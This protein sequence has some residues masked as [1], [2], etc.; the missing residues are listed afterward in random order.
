MARWWPPVKADRFVVFDAVVDVRDRVEPHRVAVAI[1]DDHRLIR[2]RVHQLAIGQHRVGAVRSVDG[3]GRQVHVRVLDGVGRVVDADPVRRQGAGIEVD[4][5]GILRRTSYLNLRHATHRGNPLRNRRFGVFVDGGDRKD[6]RAQDEL[7][8]RLVA[9]VHLLV[10]RGHRH[11]RRE[12]TRRFRNHRL[13]VL[14]RRID[15]PIE[16]ELQR[17]VRVPLRARR[18]DR[19]ETGDRRKLF[20]ERQCDRRGHR[21][22]TGTGETPLDLN[23]REVDDRQIADGQ[24]AIRHHAEDQNSEHDERRGDRTCDEECREVHGSSVREPRVNNPEDARGMDGC[25]M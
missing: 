17:D 6:R 16:I 7:Q 11:L 10:R 15:I 21:L 18:V 19:I 2:R 23:R 24:Q 22:W 20:F 9:R 14:S 3:A 13:D 5:H 8:D 1:R 25:E 4:P 12:Q